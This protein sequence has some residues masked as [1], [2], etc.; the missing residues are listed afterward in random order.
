MLTGDMLSAG[1]LVHGVI[2]VGVYKVSPDGTLDGSFIDNYHGKGF[3]KEKLT[4][5]R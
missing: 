1:Y 5:I 2:A 4:P 3:G